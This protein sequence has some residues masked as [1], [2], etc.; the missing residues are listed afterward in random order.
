MKKGLAPKKMTQYEHAVSG[1]SSA[2]AIQ[3]S[4][5]NGKDFYDIDINIMTKKEKLKHQWILETQKFQ[6]MA[7]NPESTYLELSM[8]WDLD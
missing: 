4:G 7:G 1:I 6:R 3:G 5:Y 8:E 2:K